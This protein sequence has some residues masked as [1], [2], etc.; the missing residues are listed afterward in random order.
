[1][2]NPAT[3]EQACSAL[4]APG[5]VVELFIAGYKAG[6]GR[7]RNA[8]GFYNDYAQLA[9]DAVRIDNQQIP[10]NIYMSL[11]K[12]H[13]AALARS[14]NRLDMEGMTAAGNNDFILRRHLFVDVDTNTPSGTSATEGEILIAKGTARNIRDFFNGQGWPAPFIG[15][16]GNGVHLVYRVD[17]P[18]DDVHTK[19]IRDIH[20]VLDEKFS[21]A[22]AKVD[23]VTWNMARLIRLYGTVARKGEEIGDRKHRLSVLAKPR[24]FEEAECVPLELL[25]AVA[26]LRRPPAAAARSTRPSS[27]GSKA[28]MKTRDYDLDGFLSRHGI[29]VKERKSLNGGG[30]TIVLEQ[31]LFDPS[32]VK[33]SAAIGRAAS[34][35]I[36]YKCQHA[37]CQGL[38]WAEVREMLDGP[39]PAPK[40]K[41]KD[42]GDDGGG[43]TPADLARQYIDEEWTDQ[44]LGELRL[45]RHR[46]QFYAYTYAGRCYYRVSDDELDTALTR[47]L[48]TRVD[49]V[50]RTR[51]RDIMGCIRAYVTVA[52]ADNRDLPFLSEIDIEDGTNVARPHVPNLIAMRNGILDVDAVVAGEPID[53]CLLPHTAN[54]MSTVALP[55]DFPVMKGEADCPVWLQFLDETFESDEQRINV[56]QEAMGYCFC[57]DQVFEKFFVLQ[58]S[59]RN[60]KSTVLNVLTYI[61]G[62]DCV[63]SLGPRDFQRST[64]LGQLY[65]K[66]AN[67]CGDMPH[68]DMATEDLLKSITSGDAIAADRKFREAITFRPRA[69]LWFAT[70]ELPLFADRTQ[71]IW[72]R[73]LLIPFLRVV[74]KDQID[75][76]LLEKLQAEAPGILLWALLGLRRLLKQ[77]EFTYSKVCEEAHEMQ[78]RTNFPILAFLSECTERIEGSAL[79][80]DELWGAYLDWC[81]TSG[82]AKPKPVAGFLSDI[83]EFD[84]AIVVRRETRRVL[85][86]ANVEGLMLIRD[87]GY[88][89]AGEQ[90]CFQ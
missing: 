72:R 45:R 86:Y 49:K 56:L 2:L 48:S 50:T 29:A 35:A 33:S 31:C 90:A 67:I 36:W 20:A 52:H 3:I 1:M 65:G 39:R 32:H 6:G 75:V 69:K 85:R 76:Y 63:S 81:K 21:V 47:W 70:N 28:S 82:L 9:Q 13:E 77:G 71:G 25:K 83:Q 55:F 89:N 88:R 54:W 79:S 66:L 51:V 30:E 41:G 43:D 5:D 53:H 74:P 59:G 8:V 58:G 23:P 15:F 37:S 87:A 46:Q 19:I 38:G 80:A 62:P 42:E 34:G 44:D 7:R 4:H 84:P 27:S 17:L 18:P 61:L 24:L 11:N 16:S 64:M 60:G 78:R 22:G 12:L 10:Q 68:R 40:K 14:P 73:L 57:A 26:G